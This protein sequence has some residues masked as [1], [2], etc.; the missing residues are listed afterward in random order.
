MKHLEDKNPT[1]V[2]LAMII[3]AILTV[4]IVK[5]IMQYKVL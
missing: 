2:F 1:E 3:A 5:C 4:I